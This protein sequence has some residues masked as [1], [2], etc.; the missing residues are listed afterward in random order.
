MLEFRDRKTRIFT[1]IE[2]CWNNRIKLA[3]RVFNWVLF[4]MHLIYTWLFITISKY[5]QYI[6]K[7][8]KVSVFLRKG[9]SKCQTDVFTVLCSISYTYK[10]FSIYIYQHWLIECLFL[11]LKPFFPPSSFHEY[12]H[13]S[14]EFFDEFWRVVN[15][16][17]YVRN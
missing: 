1:E 12:Y 17:R 11:H 13:I 5:I 6:Q 2:N 7:H 16:P 4:Y 10:V 8:Q 14:F 15:S 3:W 9:I